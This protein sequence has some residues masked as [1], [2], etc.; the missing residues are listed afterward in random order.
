MRYDFTITIG[1]SADD[2][3]TAWNEA[4]MALSMDPGSTPDEY[5]EIEDEDDKT[6]YI[7]A[8]EYEGGGGFD[9]YHTKEAAD[10]AREAEKVN[11]AELE[12]WE[13]FRYDII[14]PES[15]GQVPEDITTYIENCNSDKVDEI[16]AANKN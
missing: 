14:I 8:W 10:K 9:W 1:A 13:A 15:V 5:E 16:R 12:D 4:C 11:E 6:V 2:P 3:D 7:V